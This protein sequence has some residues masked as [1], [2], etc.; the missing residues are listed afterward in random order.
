MNEPARQ[1]VDRQ[2]SWQ[3]AKQAKLYSDILKALGYQERNHTVCNHGTPSWGAVKQLSM[4]DDQKTMQSETH[5]AAVTTDTLLVAT[6]V[7]QKINWNTT[8]LNEEWKKVNSMLS[9]GFEAHSRGPPN[10]QN[11][12][13][14]LTSVA[15]VP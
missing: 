15:L 9:S 14:L 7:N 6:A 2:T 10:L 11:A 13:T 12:S 3:Q 4:V 1:K 5:S 8:H